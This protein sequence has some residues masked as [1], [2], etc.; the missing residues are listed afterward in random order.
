MENKL[1]TLAIHTNEKAQML[2]KLLELE[3]IDVVLESLNNTTPLVG[4]RLMI[5]SKDLSKAIN[6]VESRHLDSDK[7]DTFERKSDGRPRILVP[8]DFSEYSMRAC[9]FAF[10]FAKSINAKVKIMHVYFNPYYPTALPITDVFAYQG[11]EAKEFQT[12]INKVRA[13]IEALCQTIDKEIEAGNF[14]PINYS[15]VLREGLPEEEI[16]AFA[17]D[18]NPELI[19]MGTRGKDQKDMDLIGSVT[20]EVIEMSKIPLIA[21]PEHTPFTDMQAVNKIAF[22]TSF[23][24]RDL[25]AFERMLKILQPFQEHIEITVL[26]FALKK[27]ETKTPKQTQEIHNLFAKKYPE[28]KINIELI[29][30]HDLLESLD[31][32]IKKEKINILSLTSSRRNIFSRMFRPSI[33]R[34]MLFHSDTPLFVMKG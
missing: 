12:V 10:N 3:G 5:K 27:S 20:A 28:L 7:D 24:D 22:L 17:K 9:E 32:F 8:I 4:V 33:S 30:T 25:L 16:V 15:Y 13:N 34:K 6:I 31:A 26:N 18:Y 14:P 19:I 2:K 23:S 1:V 11:K 29:E 21:L